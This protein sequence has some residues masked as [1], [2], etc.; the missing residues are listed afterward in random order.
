MF[1]LQSVGSVC[2]HILISIEDVTTSLGL[3]FNIEAPVLSLF[4]VWSSK[5]ETFPNEIIYYIFI[6]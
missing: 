6:K 1:K 2:T 4:P 5:V 3:S